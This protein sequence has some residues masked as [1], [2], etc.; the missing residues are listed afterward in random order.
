MNLRQKA[1]KYKQL[2][3]LYCAKTL[4]PYYIYESK[5]IE[6]YETKRIFSATLG[7][8]RERLDDAMHYEFEAELGRLAYE[9]A[10][11]TIE[12]DGNKCIVRAK[13]RCID[14]N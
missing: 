14:S 4:Q 6:V 11:K 12:F 5:N 10:K 13:F 7:N 1:K 9:K 2:V 3:E 8:D